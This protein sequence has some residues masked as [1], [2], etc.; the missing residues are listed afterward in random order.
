M[1]G[2][3][4]L[5]LELF[6]DVG[7]KLGEAGEMGPEPPP[8]PLLTG[9]GTPIPCA[10]ISG[11]LTP[12]PAMRRAGF[13]TVIEVGDSFP[14]FLL[15][16]FVKAGGGGEAFVGFE[17]VDSNSI[18]AEVGACFSDFEPRLPLE[19]LDLDFFSGVAGAGT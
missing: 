3:R 8:C 5:L 13:G 2:P 6:L 1:A 9:D 16:D 12:P 19:P 10:S 18:G 15:E 14:R 11:K 7:G 4:E 17:S